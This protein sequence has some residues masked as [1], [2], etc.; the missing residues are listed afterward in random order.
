MGM[1]DY[2]ARMYMSDI[3]I[4]GA[5]DPLAENSRRFSP[6]AYAFNNPIRFIDPDGK[7][8]EDW[9]KNSIG[10]RE[11]RDDIKS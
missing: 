7:E 8:G 10:Q 4:W 5:H 2:G 3:I 9:F 6:Y 1:Y 11:F